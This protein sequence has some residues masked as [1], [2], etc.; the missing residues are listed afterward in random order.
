MPLMEKRGAI[1]VYFPT[2]NCDWFLGLGE[3]WNSAAIRRRPTESARANSNVFG[4]P[5]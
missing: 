1:V 5:A 3:S 4:F 2:L